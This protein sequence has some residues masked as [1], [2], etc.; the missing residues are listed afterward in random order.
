MRR[1]NRLGALLGAGALVLGTVTIGVA[2]TVSVASAAGKFKACVVTDTGGINDHSFNASAWAG[3]QN[4][5]KQDKNITASYLSSTSSASYTP[6]INK[7]ISQGCGII[8][9][10]GFLMDGATAT[11]ANAHPNQKF[12]IVDD[13]PNAPK[14]KGLLALTYDTNQDAFLGGYV[15]AAMSKT[16]VVATYGGA[17]IPPVTIYMD[18]FVAGVRYYDQHMHKH[19]KVLGWTP[20]KGNRAKGQYTGKGTFVGNFTDQTAGK[21]ITSG[22]FADGADIVFPVAGGVGLGSVAAAQQ[23]GKKH[24]IMWV[25]SDGC[26]AEKADCSYFIGSVTKGVTTSVENAVLAAA[27]G[28]FKPGSYVG[29][30]ANG[31]VQFYFDSPTVPAS[32]KATVQQLTKGIESGTISVD[33]TKYPVG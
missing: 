33:P 28:T 16:G 10:V 31:G 30:L 5:T 15:A 9:T 18:G 23:A 17:D 7:F 25:D 13:V 11:A 1:I 20:S 4:A 3:L 32:L 21:T 6:N 8:V 24:S 26:F 19:V 2:T 29:T 14:S 27:K 12:A 22:F